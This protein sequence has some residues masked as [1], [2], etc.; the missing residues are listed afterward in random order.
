[1]RE[2]GDDDQGH[3]SLLNGKP[4]LSLEPDDGDGDD[5]VGGDDD[6][7]SDGS[8][9]VGGGDDDDDGSLMPEPK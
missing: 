6:G 5:D 1:M 2:G 7:D 4:R 3:N 8:D 9:D